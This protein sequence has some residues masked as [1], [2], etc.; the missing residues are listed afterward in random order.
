[1]N[2][3]TDYLELYAIATGATE[4]NGNTA[5]TYFTGALIAP[6]N[7]TAGGWQNDGTQSFLANSTDKVGIGTSTPWAL[8]SIT[9]NGITGP[10]FAVGSSSKTDFIIDNAGRVGI[11]TTSPS[12]NFIF[13]VTGNSYLQFASTTRLT[14]GTQWFASLANSGL[15]V[16]ANGKVYAAATITLADIGGTLALTKLANQNA[17]TVLANLTGGSAAPT[18]IGT[19]TLFTGSAGQVLTFANGAWTGVGTTTL[20]NG[21][22]ITTTYSATNNQW[23]IAN[24]GATFAFPFT[25]I[26]TFGTTS[27]ATSSS[28]QTSGVFFASSTAAASIFPFASTTAITVSGTASTTNLTISALNTASCDVKASPAGV[29]SCGTDATGTGTFSF[30]PSTNFNLAVNATSTPLWLK[31]GLMASTTSYFDGIGMATNSYLNFGSATGTSGYGF[32]DNA[33]VM[34]FK[35]SGGTWAGVNTATSGPSF[36]VHKNGTDQTVTASVT[37]LLTWSTETYD[38]NNNFASNRFAPTVPG[39]YLIMVNAQCNDNGESRLQESEQDDR[40]SFCLTAGTLCPAN[41]ERPCNDDRAGTTHRPSRQR[42]RLLP[43][44][45]IAHWL[46]LRSSST[47]TPI[48]S[49][50]G[51]RSSRAGRLTFSVP[52]VAAQRRSRPST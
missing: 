52:A 33:G 28:I 6:V 7:A 18:A 16:D 34:E 31:M 45:A 24:T 25:T 46:S 38:T 5:Y 12:S 13:G 29:L 17:N 47:C 51:R 32:R 43:S 49:H 9:A 23:T 48:R 1:M 36:S 21:S 20:T 41:Q 2:G 11:A 42:W 14:A 3:T 39:K 4:F 8:L 15:G 22:G 44:R 10:Q 50:R 30:T 26:S 37:T 19:T 27:A 35:N 40:W